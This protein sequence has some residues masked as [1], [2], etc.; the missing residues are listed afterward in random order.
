MDFV[1]YIGLLT[2]ILT[3]VNC[4]QTRQRHT[5]TDDYLRSADQTQGQYERAI[6]AI[7]GSW[8]L[9]NPCSV[10]CDGQGFLQRNRECSTGS[11][12]DCERGGGRSWEVTVC[13]NG[14]CTTPSGPAAWSP[15]TEKQSC[16]VTCDGG[17]KELVR[18]CSTGNYN[19]CKGQYWSVQ[20]CNKE[21]CSP[22]WLEWGA[23]SSCSMTCGLGVA[24]RYRTCNSGSLTDCTG[25]SYLLEACQ[26]KACEAPSTTPAPTTLQPAS[27][28]AWH[29]YIQC[30]KTCGVGFGE[31]VRECSSGN[32]NDCVGNAWDVSSCNI[33]DCSVDGTWAE[34]STWTSCP[35][36]CG[37]DRVTRNRSCSYGDGGTPGKPCEGDSTESRDCNTGVC[38]VDGT[39][40]DWSSWSTCSQTCDDGQQQRSRTCTFSSNAPH[41]ADC[42]GNAMETKTCS[43]GLCPADGA[44]AEWSSWS[45]CTKTCGDGIRFRARICLFDMNRPHG[46]DCTGEVSQRDTCNV[47]QCI[48]DGQWNQW[49]GWS[50][51]THTCNGGKQSRGRVCLY[52]PGFLHGAPCPGDSIAIQNC[53]T[54]ECPVDGIWGPWY[55]WGTC[56][57]S[58]DT[59]RTTR[60]RT[61]MFR[62]RDPATPHGKECDGDMTQL[63]DCNTDVCPVDARWSTWSAFTTCDK[64]CGG[65]RRARTRH[66]IYDPVAP[67]G[68]NCTGSTEESE[69]CNTVECP[70]DGVLQSW[71][72]WSHCTVTCEGGTHSR[73]RDC[74]F[75]LNRPHGDNC[76]GPLREQEICNDNMCPT[77]T[78]ATTTTTLAT[79]E[80]HWSKWDPWTIC[81]Q[82]CGTGSQY[83]ER[84]C[85][86]PDHTL[87]GEKCPGPLNQTRECNTQHCPVDGKWS[88]W[89]TYSRCSV[90]CGN[91]THT[92]SRTC[93][94]DP[95]YDSGDNCTGPASESGICQ[96]PKCPVDG[97]FQDCGAWSVCPVTC[98]GGIQDR[99]RICFFPP[100]TPHGQDC[101]NYTHENQTCNNN[102]CPVDGVLTE[103]SEWSACTVTCGGGTMYHNR[104]CYFPP[105][106]PHGL[107]CKRRLENTKTCNTNKCPV[108]GYWS[109]WSDWPK[110]SVTCDGGNQQ[111]TR[112]CVYDSHAPKGTPCAGSGSED[113]ECNTDQCPVDGNWNAWKA[114]SPCSVTCENGT[115]TRHRECHFIKTAPKGRDC[116][117][118]ALQSE[119]CNDG[120]CPVDGVWE[121]WTAWTPCTVSCGNG[122]T[123]RDRNCFFPLD[124]PHGTDCTGDTSELRS[125]NETLCPIDGVW[126]SWTTWSDCSQTCGGGN[127]TRTRNCTYDL[128][129]PRGQ[130]CPGD[131][132]ESSLCN[133]QNC[134]VDGLWSSWSNF[135][136]CTTTCGTGS[137]YRVRQCE[138]QPGYP[139]GENCTGP[140]NENSNCNENPCPVDGVWTAWVKWSVCSASCAGGTRNRSRT[141]DFPE[142]PIPHGSPC[143]GSAEAME[144]CNIEK[145]PIAG[146]WSNWS[147]PTDCSLSCGGGVQTRNRSCVFDDPDAP[148]LSECFGN[149]TETLDCNTQHC[150]V[151]GVW[152]AWNAWHQC[153]VTCGGGNRVRDRDCFFP[154]DIAQGESCA[155]QKTEIEQCNTNLC[156]V[157]GTFTAW[158]DWTSCSHT[159]GD[160]SQFRTR[161]CEFNGG[162]P[163]V[164]CTGNYSDSQTCNIAVC[165]VDGKWAAWEQWTY[166]TATCGTGSRSR[167]RTCFF[168]SDKPKGDNCTGPDS[169]S[170]IC[171]T[172]L[173]PV[174]GTWNQWGSWTPCVETC[175]NGTS[176]RNRTC[177]YLPL[178]SPPGN[179]CPESDRD[180]KYCNTDP[181]PVDGVWGFWTHWTA[182]D[183]TCGGGNKTRDRPC[184][185][186]SDHPH[187]DNCTGNSQEMDICN[188]NLCPV[189]GDWGSWGEWTKCSA[190][191]N[192][193]QHSR[194]R[195]CVYDPVAPKGAKCLGRDHMAGFC[196]DGYCPQDG[197]LSEW[198]TWSACSVTCGDGMESRDRSCVY[199]IPLA[200]HG[201]PC[202]GET[203]NTRACLNVTQ[204]TV[205]GVWSEWSTYGACSV[206]CGNGDKI[207]T[208]TC[209][210][211]PGHPQGHNC[212]GNSTQSIGCTMRSCPVDGVWESWEAWDVCTRTCG[213]GTKVRTRD[214]FFPPRV[215]QGD[216]C[217]TGKSKETV[218]CNTNQCAVDGTPGQWTEWTSCTVSCGG[219]TQTRTRNCTYPENSVHG[220]E[221][222]DS[223][224]E[225]RN[226][227]SD[228][229]RVDGVWSLWSAWGACSV[230][231]ADG[232]QLRTRSCTFPPD[233]AKGKDC[234]G[235]GNA[236]Q[237]CNLGGCP[238]DGFW[239]A[240]ESWSACSVTC[241][242]GQQTRD[243][244]CTF[245]PDAVKGTEC[246]GQPQ[247]HQQCNDGPCTKATT[248]P[249]A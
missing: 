230:T 135:T 145:C 117:G 91:G 58:C 249:M 165:P 14:P 5:E 235:N 90:S 9:T 85:T 26:V 27:W 203:N 62:T 213:T 18:T 101:G 52:T 1:K 186:P 156:P 139:H 3:T 10:S 138:F 29:T 99:T 144:N 187:G 37:T 232:T 226:C 171:N 71:K 173:C 158:S 164:N 168:P 201:K 128:L 95:R 152:K 153:S 143:N 163:G 183:V 75:P 172:Q 189:N 141:C 24:A 103:W 76:T 81:T 194:N 111:R 220:E 70:V 237:T 155:G 17:Y 118:S 51:C 179:P 184:N 66:C 105:D 162:P 246:Q 25:K 7:W 180:V 175:G 248:T 240:W 224:S 4:Q 133:I 45:D 21:P 149:T 211:T 218:D 40:A 170:A 68:L 49:G 178:G 134:P 167:N 100:D 129:A 72:S 177:E 142:P 38:P 98:G 231:C 120:I 36:T 20:G 210:F 6:P 160:G 151:D 223:L 84:H 212:V 161:K 182:C 132:V 33:A 225:N 23:Q 97:V 50:Q 131:A 44:W 130:E 121:S 116:N 219:G 124:V 227:N 12:S 205:D 69:Q 96:A 199:P 206:T 13:N 77:T 233:A 195:T 193:G 57:Q 188:T 106:V 190:T 136:E 16:S 127:T 229:C 176:T 241:G 47:K 28:T 221:C 83:R 181:C 247:D 31:R 236:T 32:N 154:P 94:F 74:Y 30:S 19:D 146:H 67:M 11:I 54:S 122:T 126:A 86:Y 123:T 217:T 215:T 42:P 60:S 46:A 108:D 169:D 202:E 102:K 8:Q 114:W 214:C 191:C 65:G 89:S 174:D 55:P 222:K 104:T 137:Q 41:G 234:G 15:W 159:C 148:H 198:G 208:R 150:P 113:R 92:R 216:F 242:N 244:N 56:S 166:C 207:R 228:V 73:T 110:C 53:G 192:I 61:C 238:V 35:V 185:F 119:G 43:Q 59:G 48:A 243:R 2:C 115:H 209:D 147:L 204:C 39:W 197:V 107:D 109:A 245:P 112:H 34:W 88:D 79:V 200:P 22:E 80:G 64:T 63:K 140:S 93:D 196:N 125:C 239:G 78:P 87:H 157:N 82:S